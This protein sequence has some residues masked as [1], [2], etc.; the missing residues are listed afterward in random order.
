MMEPFEKLARANPGGGPPPPQGF[1]AMMTAMGGV[2]AVIMFL[3]SAVY[4]I[5]L[6]ICMTRPEVREAFDGP[7]VDEVF[8]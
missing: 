6:L 7:V 5:A 4:P 3:M 1:M 2:A 8:E